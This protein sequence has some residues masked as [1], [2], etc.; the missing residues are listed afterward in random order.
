MA[1]CKRCGYEWEA[2]AANPKECP[3]CK[4]RTWQVE[5]GG[6][7]GGRRM[8]QPVDL[9]RDGQTIGDSSSKPECPDCGE[10]MFENRKQRK[11]WCKCGYQEP[12]K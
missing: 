1:V 4:S 5:R 2:R 11:W 8:V 9:E 10:V 12:M 7:D 6:V 3:E